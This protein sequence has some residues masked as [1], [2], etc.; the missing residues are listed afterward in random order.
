[1]LQPEA[2]RGRDTVVVG[3]L[4]ERLARRRVAIVLVRRVAGPVPG[5]R[6]DFADQQRVGLTVGHEDGRDR[7]VQRAVAARLAVELA[8][9]TSGSSE[10]AATGTSHQPS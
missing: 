2:A 8:A 9:G 1:A 6:D 4:E 7:P 10:T 5:G 3:L